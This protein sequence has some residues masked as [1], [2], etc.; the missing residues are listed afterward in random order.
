M[1][2]NTH[3]LKCA[4]NRHKNICKCTYKSIQTITCHSATLTLDVEQPLE[5]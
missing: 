1:N 3:K 5:V 2:T 4:H